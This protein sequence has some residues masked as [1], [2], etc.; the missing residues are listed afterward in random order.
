M[1][2][3]C[4]LFDSNYL[5]KGI[6][7]ANSLNRHAQDF[8][9]YIYAFDQKAYDILLK[10]QIKNVKPILFEDIISDELIQIR[11]QRTRAEFCWTCTP[12]ILEYTF[13]HYNV[14]ICT[15]IDADL[16]FYDDPEIL[17][18]EMFENH[19]SVQIVEHRFP[20]T[21]EY[22]RD[23]ELSGR[24]CVEFNTFLNDE[25][26]RKVLKWWREQCFACCTSDWSKGSFGDQKYLD[27]WQGKFGGIN[28]L[29]NHGGGM[30]PWNIGRYECFKGKDDRKIEF[31]EG[32]TGEQYQ[33]VF[34]HF[35]DLHFLSDS[36]IDINIF[37]RHKKI[38]KRLVDRIYIPYLNEI[39]TI[40]NILK[41]EYCCEYQYTWKKDFYYLWNEGEVLSAGEKC[42]RIIKLPYMLYKRIFVVKKDIIKIDENKIDNEV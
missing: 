23:E 9:L 39:A 1:L 29:Q 38:D 8:C 27:E 35:H 41:K 30:A 36:K 4:T 18:K 33:L 34:Y 26:G 16:Y 25:K 24:Y 3:F 15:Y 31:A 13:N 11:K 22:K 40:R 10:M 6:A 14:D 42:K 32:E 37:L 5:D 20:A 19:C 28:V 7:L 12:Y 17:I 2:N 21:K